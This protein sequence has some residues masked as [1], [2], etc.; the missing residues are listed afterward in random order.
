M[1]YAI[2]TSDNNLV[3]IAANDSDRDAL[4]IMQSLC[5]IKDISDSNFTKL[6]LNTAGITYDGTNV[7]ITD[8]DD[9]LTRAANNLNRQVSDSTKD[10]LINFG[11]QADLDGYLK[12]IT[13]RLGDFVKNNSS[14]SMYTVCN[15][16]L[17]YLN[18]LDT[19]SL[20]YPLGKS[21][22]QYCTDNSI[23]FVHPLQIP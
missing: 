4:N 21:W 1:A 13:D 5:V 18:S 19:S 3:H 22:E 23:S 17:T 16:Y 14:N 10:K 11:A 2:F 8:Y 6:Q 7:T 20:S 15:N 12:N 9:G